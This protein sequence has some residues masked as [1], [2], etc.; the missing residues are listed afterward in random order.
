MR[1]VFERLKVVVDANSAAC[2]AA[3]FS[4]AFMQCCDSKEYRYERASVA[5]ITM[6][7]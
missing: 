1:F 7:T 5:M 3:L 2:V 4:D 6:L